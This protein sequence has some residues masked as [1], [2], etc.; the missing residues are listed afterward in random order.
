M[1]FGQLTSEK[2]IPGSIFT[3]ASLKKEETCRMTE[4]LVNVILRLRSFASPEPTATIRGV[5]RV[6]RPNHG[7]F[8]FYFLFFLMVVLRGARI[9][10]AI[11]RA[12]RNENGDPVGFRAH[13]KMMNPFHLFLFILELK[14]KLWKDL[15]LVRYIKIFR[16]LILLMIAIHEIVILLYLLHL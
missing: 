10:Y 9:T 8:F 5:G 11:H 12:S 14:I 2:W 13:D 7:L 16:F 3:L 15:F 1:E 4:F 6:G